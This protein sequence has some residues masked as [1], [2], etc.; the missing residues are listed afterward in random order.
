MLLIV[1]LGIIIYSLLIT[2]LI[3]KFCLQE[4]LTR[5]FTCFEK[6]MLWKDVVLKVGFWRKIFLKAFLI[7]I[8]FFSFFILRICVDYTLQK[9]PLSIPLFNFVIIF[10]VGIVSLAAILIIFF[11]NRVG[12]K[13]F[14]LELLISASLIIFL[15]G[16]LLRAHFLT[17]VLGLM[18]NIFM[19]IRNFFKIKVISS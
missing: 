13:S 15:M 14:S 18:I 11:K 12:L 3:I 2:P 5:S 10:I 17:V 1:N 9:N 16:D 7:I 8:A 19:F 6:R 4:F